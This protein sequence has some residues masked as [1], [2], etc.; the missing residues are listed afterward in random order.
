MV[1]ESQLLVPTPPAA[2]P[3]RPPSPAAPPG[4]LSVQQLQQLAEAL[5]K[6]APAGFLATADAVELMLRMASQGTG[7][8]GVRL[9]LPTRS[10]VCRAVQWLMQC[11]SSCNMFLLRGKADIHNQIHERKRPCL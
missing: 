11:T 7:C 8:F 2:P 4:V 1:D 3:V 5:G 9:A 10:A 6:A